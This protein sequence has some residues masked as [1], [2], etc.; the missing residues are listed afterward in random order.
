MS[1]QLLLEERGMER[2][3]GGERQGDGERERERRGRAERG[4]ERPINNCNV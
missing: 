3:K 2:G 4:G 1:I